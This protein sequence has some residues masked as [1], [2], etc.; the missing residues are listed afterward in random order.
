M[1]KKEKYSY[2]LLPV[3]RAFRCSLADEEVQGIF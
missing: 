3:Q 2:Q 1:V